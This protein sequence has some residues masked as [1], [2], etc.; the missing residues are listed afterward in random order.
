MEFEQGAGGELGDQDGKPAKMRALHSSAALFCNVF[1]Y[2]RQTDPAVI[3]QVLGV[4]DPIVSVHFEKP[5]R[6]GLRGTAPALDLLLVGKEGLAWGVES[7]FTQPYRAAAP[8]HSLTS[9]LSSAIILSAM[10]SGID[11]PLPYL[12]CGRFQPE[13]GELVSCNG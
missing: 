11:S 4:P 2:W 10:P 3:G 13:A 9:P 5:L 1:E 12:N 7:K 8:V 6:T